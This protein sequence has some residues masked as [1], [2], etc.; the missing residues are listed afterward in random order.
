MPVI[1]KSLVLSTLGLK[2]PL[3]SIITLVAVVPLISVLKYKKLLV[4]EFLA[5][6]ISL[7]APPSCNLNLPG[8]PA[9]PYNKRVVSILAPILLV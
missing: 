9:S 8:L 2:C 5:T 4:S 7:N 6:I 1:P 3:S